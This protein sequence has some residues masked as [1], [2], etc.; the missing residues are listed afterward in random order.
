LVVKIKEEP[1]DDGYEENEEDNFME[2]SSI[3]NNFIEGEFFFKISFKKIVCI[4]RDF[5][6]RLFSIFWIH[7][8]V[9]YL[10][11]TDEFKKKKNHWIY[12]IT[13][14][15]DSN[16]CIFVKFL[17]LFTLLNGLQLGI[18]L[19]TSDFSCIESSPI[20]KPCP[21]ITKH[22]FH[23]LKIHS[24]IIRHAN[25]PFVKK[26]IYKISSMA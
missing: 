6:D 20:M 15:G 18:I 22:Y 26:V 23:I 14:Q 9:C 12:Q 17:Y 2:V 10:K 25:A 19:N 7:N 16:P 1:K 8:L 4:F 21:K 24:F 11:K 5:V 13:F 3:A